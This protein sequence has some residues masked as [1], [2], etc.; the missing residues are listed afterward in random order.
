MTPVEVFPA[1]TMQGGHALNAANWQSPLPCDPM[2]APASAGA[3]SESRRR[4]SPEC[5]PRARKAF[6]GGQLAL[7]TVPFETIGVEPAGEPFL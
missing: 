4:G 1:E 7:T 2:R 5:L 6:K 3:C